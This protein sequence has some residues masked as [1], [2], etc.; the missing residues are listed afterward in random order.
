MESMMFSIKKSFPTFLCSCPRN[1]FSFSLVE[2]LVVVAILSILLS[3]LQPALVK[4]IYRTKKITCINNLKQLSTGLLLY[5]DDHNNLFPPVRD[6]QQATWLGGYSRLNFGTTIKAVRPY[7]GSKDLQKTEIENCPLGR[8][9]D[10]TIST[11]NQYISYAMYNS[12]SVHGG[13]HPIMKRLDDAFWPEHD[14]AY[15]TKILLSDILGV[16]GNGL[17]TNHHE[18][19]PQY[20]PQSISHAPSAFLSK[21]ALYPEAS[22]NYAGQDGSVKEYQKPFSERFPLGFTGIGGTDKVLMLPNELLE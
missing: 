13:D 15:S 12:L 9:I 22:A 10:S 7:W 16:W 3:I 14:Q 20:F 17:M 21:G 19:A 6:E 1:R 18:L 5:S 8:P 11:Q 2:L 4:C